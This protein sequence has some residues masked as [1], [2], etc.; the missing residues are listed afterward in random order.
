[1]NQ[2]PLDL[3]RVI[4]SGSTIWTIKQVLLTC[5]IFYV[6]LLTVDFLTKRFHITNQD[7][8]LSS[9]K[10]NKNPELKTQ[11]HLN[12]LKKKIKQLFTLSHFT[13]WTLV[14]NKDLLAPCQVTHL[15]NV[16]VIRI[17]ISDLLNC[18]FSDDPEDLYISF[19]TNKDFVYGTAV[20]IMKSYN[21]VYVSHPSLDQLIK[22]K[23]LVSVNIVV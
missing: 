7:I 22:F 18:K 6:R 20:T 13:K 5:K 14:D 23:E 10:K 1:M 9:I 17:L 12:L 15:L 4:L 11:Q 3:I 16:F 8:N 19:D 2:L 21:R